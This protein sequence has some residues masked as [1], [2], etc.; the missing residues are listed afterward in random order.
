MDSLLERQA[1]ASWMS[2]DVIRFI[3]HNKLLLVTVRPSWS[4]TL[5]PAGKQFISENGEGGDH[6]MPKFKFE[7]TY[8]F[9]AVYKVQDW[10]QDW[11][12]KCV[13]FYSTA[14][15]YGADGNGSRVWNY[16]EEEFKREVLDVVGYLHWDGCAFDGPPPIEWAGQLNT[17]FKEQFDLARQRFPDLPEDDYFQLLGVAQLSPNGAGWIKTDLPSVTEP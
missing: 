5:T 9:Q 16:T 2:P 10:G 13:A 11:H 14:P 7:L 3:E 1:S 12:D 8:R 6:K 4:I 17:M 15:D